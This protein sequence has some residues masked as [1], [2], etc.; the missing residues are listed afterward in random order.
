MLSLNK[1]RQEL[2][3]PSVSANVAKVD[4]NSNNPN[5]DSEDQ[6]SGTEHYY[7]TATRGRG[8]GK[9]RGRGQ[10]KAQFAPTGGKCQICGKPNHDAVNCWHRYDPPYAK[11]YARGYNVGQSSRPTHFNP[12]FRPTAHLAM[13]Q[14]YP[15]IPDMET[16]STASCV[17][18]LC[19]LDI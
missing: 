15:L 12:Y 2:T 1:N 17:T 13:P 11:P 16:L 3:N 4:S 14:Y 19:P 5:V 18:M 9:G 10:G 6:E 7:V 8:R